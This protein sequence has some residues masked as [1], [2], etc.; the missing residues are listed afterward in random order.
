MRFSTVKFCSKLGRFLF[1][2]EKWKSL[3]SAKRYQ[4]VLLRTYLAV[5]RKQ[6]EF[7]GPNFDKKCPGSEKENEEGRKT[8]TLSSTTW[9]HFAKHCWKLL[10]KPGAFNR[11]FRKNA[12]NSGEKI[13][14]WTLHKKKDECR[15][16]SE[17]FALS[18]KV[19]CSKHKINK[20][21]RLGRNATLFVC[22]RFLQFW[23]QCQFFKPNSEKD[24]FR[25]RENWYFSEEKTN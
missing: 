14:K 4:I 16:L 3:S 7:F 24:L 13:R 10:R 20:L 5:L 22:S 6:P 19:S 25:V 18:S 12:F 15:F 17:N 1:K 11:T 8:K 21:F 2:V 9:M 23:V